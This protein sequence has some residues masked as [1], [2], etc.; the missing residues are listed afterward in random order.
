M[1]P[2]DPRLMELSFAYEALRNFGMAKLGDFELLSRGQL[3]SVRNFGTK[4][5]FEAEELM[6]RFGL[7]FEKEA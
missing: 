1:E 6:E 4:C 3:E 5:M 2:L 7:H